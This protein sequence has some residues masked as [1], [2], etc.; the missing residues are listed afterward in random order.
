M[1]AVHCKL[2]AQL[3]SAWKYFRIMAVHSTYYGGY[4][5]HNLFGEHSTFLNIYNLHFWEH[6]GHLLDVYVWRRSPSCTFPMRAGRLL[7]SR[8]PLS[9][10]LLHLRSLKHC[11][12]LAPQ[13]MAMLMT[14]LGTVVHTCTEIYPNL[15]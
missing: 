15:Y 5:F 1:F 13:Q 4:C 8:S 2:W 7:A 9:F 10:A 11:I 6:M 12:R 14:S 3:L